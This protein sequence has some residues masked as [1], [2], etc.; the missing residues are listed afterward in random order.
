MGVE[1]PHWSKLAAIRIVFSTLAVLMLLSFAMTDGHQ[2][3]DHFR[4][5]PVSRQIKQHT[6]IAQPAT[7]RVDDIAHKAVNPIVP[8][9]SPVIS[10]A[11]IFLETGP[12]ENE[13]P[14]ARYLLRIKLGSSREDSSPPL[15][16]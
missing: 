12:R 8:I 3:T 10:A 7:N 15:L 4:T 14:V 5:A 9:M 11:P 6:S 13:R 2:F 1:M 16:Q